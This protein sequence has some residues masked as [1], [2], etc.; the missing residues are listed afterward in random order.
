MGLSSITT[1]YGFG[2]AGGYYHRGE[3]QWSG[4]SDGSLLGRM[5]DVC[6]GGEGAAR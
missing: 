4:H 3:L 1:H 6:T 2:E 5:G